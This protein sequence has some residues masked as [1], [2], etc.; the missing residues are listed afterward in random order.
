MP[1]QF[2]KKLQKGEVLK[3]NLVITNN[4]CERECTHV[5]GLVRSLSLTLLTASPRERTS[6]RLLVITKLTLPYVLFYHTISRF[7]KR[8]RH[9]G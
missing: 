1:D 5:V 2:A 9:I 7:G 4:F 3:V 8:F 6:P